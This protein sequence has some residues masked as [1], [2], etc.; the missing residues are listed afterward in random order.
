MENHNNKIE[1]IKE[2]NQLHLEK[3]S[4]H[5][6]LVRNSFR[7]K[8]GNAIARIAEILLFKKT[9]LLS[10]DHLEKNLDILKKINNTS[11]VL[12]KKV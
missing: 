6:D 9:P 4:K 1:G 11:P 2:L 5:L 10:I 3:M 7:W 8:V 12:K